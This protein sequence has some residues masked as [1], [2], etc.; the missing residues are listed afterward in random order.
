[1]EIVE[2][3]LTAVGLWD[4][5]KDRMKQPALAPFGGNET[6]ALHRPGSHRRAGHHPS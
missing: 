6:K 1:M 2:R 4:E 5:I 3:C